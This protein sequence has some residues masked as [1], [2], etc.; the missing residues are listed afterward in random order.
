MFAAAF[1]LAATVAASELPESL[2]PE[3]FRAGTSVLVQIEEQ[4]TFRRGLYG[5]IWAGWGA[6]VLGNA[7]MSYMREQGHG[8]RAGDRWVMAAASLGAAAGWTAVVTG[9]ADEPDR[10]LALRSLGS[11]LTGA[12][13]GF[14][15]WFVVDRLTANR[16]DSRGGALAVGGVLSVVLSGWLCQ[17]L[18]K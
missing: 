1:A 5:H 16:K 6:F 4:N 12:A 9:T 15:P 13:A 2:R 17:Q 8:E 14:G 11:S 7:T 18:A 10:Q 3:P